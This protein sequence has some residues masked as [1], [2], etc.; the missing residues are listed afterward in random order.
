MDSTYRGEGEEERREK[1]EEKGEGRERREKP[2]TI[3]HFIHM[4]SF[5]IWHHRKLNSK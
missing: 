2:Y 1:R 3:L 4:F 5:I